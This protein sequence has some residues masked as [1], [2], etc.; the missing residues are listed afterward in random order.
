MG[1]RDEV[2]VLSIVLDEHVLD[3]I[4]EGFEDLLANLLMGVNI[5]GG[6][7]NSGKFIFSHLWFFLV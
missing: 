7:H 5:T 6:L 1:K 2:F 3:F 4:L